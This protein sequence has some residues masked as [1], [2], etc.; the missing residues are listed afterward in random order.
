MQIIF[1]SSELPHRKRTPQQ[2]VNRL[3]SD[4][5]LLEMIEQIQLGNTYQDVTTGKD[6]PI[7][8]LWTRF[9]RINLNNYLQ[10]I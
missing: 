8:T 5:E 6:V 2:A 3:W 10:K 1:R 4:N 7:A 9:A